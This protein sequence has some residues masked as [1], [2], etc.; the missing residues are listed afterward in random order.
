[1]EGFDHLSAIYEGWFHK[2]SSGT[3]IAVSP[4]GISVFDPNA[5]KRSQ[6][7]TTPVLTKLAI[8]NITINGRSA[9]SNPDF[10]IDSDVCVLDELTLDYLHNNFTLEFSSM[11]MT[12]PQKN[13]YRH[14]L[15]GYDPDWIETDFRNRTATYTN[16]PAG[17]Y[18]FKVR[19]SNRHGV[20]SENERTL[21]VKILPPPWRSS[22]A[23][24]G[25]GLLVIGL[26][27]LA[28]RNIVQRE[29]L[30]S[31]LKLAK[32]EQ[33]KEHFELEKAIE[34]DKVKSTFFAN[35]SHEFRT[36]LT[37]IK[38]PVQNLLEQFADHPNVKGTTQTCSTQF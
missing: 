29:R 15:E 1:M 27:I 38:G 21:K 18:T 10:T 34:V 31:N 30:K 33:E 24:T 25:Y 35:I 2:T 37:L 16:L 3:F 23:Y 6:R 19:A 13:L 11:E 5:F 7:K 8:N 26:L 32:V 28:R 4:D 14:K 12:S 17:E 20:W 36:P 22:W 9:P